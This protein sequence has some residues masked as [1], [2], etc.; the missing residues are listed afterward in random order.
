[1]NKFAIFI[2][3]DGV[4]IHEENS[5]RPKTVDRTKSSNFIFSE[6]AV[7]AIMKVLNYLETLDYEPI[8]VLS[9]SWIKY[10]NKSVLNDIL[11]TYFDSKYIDDELT[12]GCTTTSIRY[13][14]IEEWLDNFDSKLRGTNSFFILDDSDSGT[15]LSDF[16]NNFELYPSYIDHRT[17]LVDYDDSKI[18]N[19]K[20][21]NVVTSQIFWL[22][23]E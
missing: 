1:M 20:L 17:L 8:L 15:A 6:T 21:A 12:F 2:D 13:F 19:E 23:T 3:F 4:L 10:L 14:R 5:V 22:E 9:T 7:T 18:F 11:L 16:R